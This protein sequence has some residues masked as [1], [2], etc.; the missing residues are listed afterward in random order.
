M[1]GRK[2]GPR[3]LNSILQGASSPTPRLDF[4]AGPGVRDDPSGAE[5]RLQHTWRFPGQTVRR[6]HSMPVT[7]SRKGKGFQWLRALA[8]SSLVS[9]LCGGGS[10]PEACDQLLR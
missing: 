7:R 4:F 6:S 10:W 9:G 5:G 2:G 3:G 1:A 8:T